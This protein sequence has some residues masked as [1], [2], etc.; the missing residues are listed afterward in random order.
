MKKRKGFVSNSSSTSFIIAVRKGKPC[1]HCGRG[2]I[3]FIELIRSE[4]DNYCDNTKLCNEG[5]ED[6]LQERITYCGYNDEMT[7][8]LKAKLEEAL[9]NGMKVAEIRVSYHDDTTKRLMED[10][11]AHENLVIIEEDER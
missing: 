7:K 2:D 6:I 8:N 1:E 3:D 5:I 4:Q 10:L 11:E 9:S